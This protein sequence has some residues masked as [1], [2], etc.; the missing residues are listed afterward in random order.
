MDK[1]LERTSYWLFIPPE[2]DFALSGKTA[3]SMGLTYEGYV[4]G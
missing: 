1:M 2:Q 3:K 4:V